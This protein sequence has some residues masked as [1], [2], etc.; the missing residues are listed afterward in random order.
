MSS[1]SRNTIWSFFSI[2]GVQFINILTNVVLARILSP[3][4][5]GI[6]GMAIVFAGFAFVVQEA[7]LN[8][9]LIFKKGEIQK[10]IS[11]TFWLNIIFS[12][13][14][15]GI[16]HFSSG[17]IVNFY[18][19]KQ[20]ITILNFICIGILVGSIGSTHRAL[21]I[22][23]NQFKDITKIDILA[24]VV[25]SIAAILLALYTNGLL[26]VSAKY[27]FRP[28]IQS[29]LVFN[30]SRHRIKFK[31]YIEELKE[32]ILYSGNVLGSQLLMYMNNNV[33]FFLV[34]RF[35]GD[36]ILGI[37]T[38]AFQWGALARYYLSGAVM[39]VVF[40]EVS[41]QQD[42][43][44]KLKGMYLNVISKLAFITLPICFGLA[45]VAHE[46]IYVLYGEKWMDVVPIL[47][48]LL[49]AGGISSVSVVGGP[50]LRGMG[51][52]DLEMKLSVFS[53]ISFTAL[54]LA[55]VKHGLLA[56]AIAECCRVVLIETTRL[57]LIRKYLGVPVRAV[58]KQLMPTVQSLVL[59]IIVLYGINLLAI[60]VNVLILFVLKI[61][62]GVAVYIAGSFIFNK[63]QSKWIL[64]YVKKK[65]AA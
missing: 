2:V 13:I 22:K 36:K 52:P 15:A 46:F 23:N 24:E 20:V 64:N 34:G 65:Q 60:E 5:F 41:R 39:R 44:S 63:S 35:L 42:D 7:G 47:Q 43:P 54:V 1:I 10:V 45:L 33:D 55:G 9:Y 17:A 56:V 32:L 28:L 57:W 30:Y 8:S 12:F 21:L 26:A 38:L 37:Y 27:V 59:M 4:T 49:L 61:A 40:P 19:N 48:L 62:I 16:L 18:N 53:F 3:E 25:S 31:I 50:V 6:L 29:L 11:T 51:R 14:L 58:F